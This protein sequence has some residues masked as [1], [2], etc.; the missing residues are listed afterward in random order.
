VLAGDRARGWPEK[1]IIFKGGATPD[2]VREKIC[3]ARLLGRVLGKSV[4]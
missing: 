2:I 1:P 4:P 3:G